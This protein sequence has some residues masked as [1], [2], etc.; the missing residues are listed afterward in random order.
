MT[1]HS[2]SATNLSDG[3]QL[4]STTTNNE[5]QIIAGPHV[6]NGVVYTTILNLTDNSGNGLQSVVA[7]FKAASGAKLWQ[8]E[9]IGGGPFGI[10]LVNNVIYVGTDNGTLYAYD[11]QQGKRIWSHSTTGSIQSAPFVADGVIY[12]SEDIG[13]SL[14][15]KVVAVNASNGQEKWHASVKGGH[16]SFSSTMALSTWRVTALSMLPAQSMHS[17]LRM[18]RSSGIP[19]SLAVRRR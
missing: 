7:A 2:L 10:T 8:S 3:K 13:F 14:S 1:S 11:A 5:N 12:T 15:E 17:R 6:A 16:P 4:W 18:V 19:R 9:P